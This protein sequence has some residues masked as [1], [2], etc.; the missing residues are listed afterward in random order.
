MIKT[1]YT[2]IL[3]NFDNFSQAPV[4]R[5]SRTMK[6]RVFECHPPPAVVINAENVELTNGKM[7]DEVRLS[8]CR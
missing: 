1:Y 3:N 6:R 8:N 4:C 5:G 2:F 7:T